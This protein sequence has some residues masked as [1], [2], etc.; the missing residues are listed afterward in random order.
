LESAGV[1]EPKR[2]IEVY[3]LLHEL[4]VIAK[5]KGLVESF[6][7][8]ANRIGYVGMILSKSRSLEFIA[9]YDALIA[10]ITELVERH[11][12]AKLSDYISLV[13]KM[14]IHNVSIRA[15]SVTSYPGKI[16]LMTTHKSKGLEYD[17]VYITHLNEGHWG[18]RRNNTYFLPI[19]A[20]GAESLE[21]DM[22]DERRLLYV[23]VTRAKKE[24]HL[25]YANRRLN[26]KELL[27][28]RFLEEMNSSLVKTEKVQTNPSKILTKIA[29]T[30][31][32]Q[33]LDIKNREYLSALFLDSGFSVSALNNYLTCPWRFFFQNLIR[34]PQVEERHQLYGT[35]IHEA[36]RTFFDEYKN[37]RPMTKKDFLDYFEKTL[38]RK[39]L[40]DSDYE[41][42][43]KRGQESLGGY[44]DTYKGTWSKDIFNEFSIS[45]VHI[46]V[47]VDGKAE[48]VLL[49]GQLDKIELHDGSANVVDYKTGNPKSRREIEGE[50]ASSEGNYKRQLVFYKILID[51]SAKSKFTMKT[52]E[53]DFVEPNK[54]GNYKKE[55]FEVT[56]ADVAELIPVIK[57]AAKEILTLSFWDTNCKEPACGFCEM[58]KLMEAGEE[59][60]S[61]KK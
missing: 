26:G 3:Q 21:S 57:Q 32:K 58:K 5:N 47:D 40:S 14:A 4:S 24:V 16:N 13:D 61:K 12:Y 11:K 10:H 46:P 54:Q 7:E 9:S 43:L 44:Y 51:Q 53:I 42:F 41:L 29:T 28:S 52:G 33:E 17:S 2:F 36:L 55:K 37:D 8:I 23:A 34:V 35:S 39:A 18:G 19:D 15:K 50:T 6:Q 48:Q 45:D 20:Q 60:E 25:T 56:D 22:A 38:N 27:P 59:I 1:D 30:K 49:R 31:P